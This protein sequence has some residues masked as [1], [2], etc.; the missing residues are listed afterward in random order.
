[1]VERDDGGLT[2]TAQRVCADRSLLEIALAPPLPVTREPGP[3]MNVWRRD[4][5]D[6]TF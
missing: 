2:W 3:L 1:M 5:E 6:A 4:G